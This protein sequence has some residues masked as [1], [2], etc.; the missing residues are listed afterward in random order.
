MRR[1]DKYPDFVS[2]G[3][4][5]ALIGAIFAL[6]VFLAVIVFAFNVI[7]KSAKILVGQEE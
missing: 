3:S 7:A 4:D 5:L 6:V 1:I 2:V